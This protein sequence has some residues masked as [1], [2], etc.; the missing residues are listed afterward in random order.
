MPVL[1]FHQ[2]NRTFF[3]PSA[4]ATLVPYDDIYFLGGCITV[5]A[6]HDKTFYACK[7]RGEQVFQCLALF[8]RILRLQGLVVFRADE[9]LTI[10]NQM[11]RADKLVYLECNYIPEISLLRDEVKGATPHRINDLRSVTVGT[12][13]D[14]GRSRLQLLNFQ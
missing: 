10:S 7:Q 5:S 11:K 2:D 14:Y 9:Q 8:M 3:L 4:L 6:D 1:T 13:H 12:H